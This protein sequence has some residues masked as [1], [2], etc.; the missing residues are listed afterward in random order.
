MFSNTMF[1]DKWGLALCAAVVSLIVAATY[2]PVAHAQFVYDDITDFQ[3]M[4]WLRHG[5]EWIHLL[6]RGFNN[7]LNY[8]RPLVVAL[9]TMQLRVFDTQPGPMH[10][11]SLAFHV[12][13]T[14][15]VGVLA[16][17]IATHGTLQQRR[18][19]VFGM[20]TLLYGL[21]PLL[22][23]TVVWIGCQ[24]E[25]VA[26]FFMLL[27]WIANI[28]ITRPARRA[29][30]VAICFFLAACSKESAAAFPFIL[31]VLDW[32]ARR[33]PND[34]RISSRVR[35]LLGQNWLTY[36]AIIA[37]GI[38]YLVI[39]YFSLG[40]LVPGADAHPLPFWARLQQASFLYLRYWQ[41]FFWPTVGM[42]PL[43]A[44]PTQQFLAFN[45]SMMLQDMGAACILIAGIWM[46]LR[47]IYFGAL[48]LCVTFALLPVLYLIGPHFDAS[49]YHERYATTALAIACSWLPSGFKQTSIPLHAS[50]LLS[51]AGRLIL[52]AWLVLAVITVHLTIP[53]WST[54]I[55]LWTWAV[56]QNPTDVGAKDE[57][58]SAYIDQQDFASAWKLIDDIVKKGERC[59]NCMLNAASMSVTE[60][61]PHRADFFLQKVKE[62]PELYTQP[63]YRFYLTIAGR[64]E[65]LEGNYKQAESLARVAISQDKLDPQPQK[66]LA[67]ALAMRGQI[68]AATQAE[69]IALSLL[70][71]DEQATERERFRQLMDYVRSHPVTN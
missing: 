31:V 18:H 7:W 8:F 63:R 29:L 56:Q 58:I 42:G 46:A 60:Q 65:L 30:T 53:L 10:L 23:E 64:V 45:L 11:V 49:L 26:T 52:A 47:R 14:L 68:G 15:L 21:H 38:A 20:S 37:T 70:T 4:A 24:F 39:R 57:L 61:N 55:N 5:D 33:E 51:P 62:L 27:G 44:V 32:F 22:I 36:T 19:W 43:H 40:S 50:R 48:I 35:T 41:M 6:F 9:F 34:E 16:L 59:V 1:R 12:A 2:W 69:G 17:K 25:L 28:G 54:Q 67:V 71:A 13:N 3:R 66:L